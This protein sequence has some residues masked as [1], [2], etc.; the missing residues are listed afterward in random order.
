MATMSS[1]PA[2]FQVSGEIMPLEMREPI[3][4]HL[5]EL[6]LL[7]QDLFSELAPSNFSQAG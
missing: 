5:Q 3:Q 2:P 7:E 6:G 4:D 1:I